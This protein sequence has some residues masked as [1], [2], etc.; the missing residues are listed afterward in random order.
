M[1]VGGVLMGTTYVVKVFDG[2]DTIEVCRTNNLEEAV[3][4]M[5]EEKRAGRGCIILE[6]RP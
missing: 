2:H 4:S 1:E 6:W 3:L 5:M